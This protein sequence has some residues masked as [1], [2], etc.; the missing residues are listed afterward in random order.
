MS[1][2]DQWQAGLCDM[3]SLS[4]ENNS[5]TFLLTVIDCF[6]KFAWVEQLLNKSGQ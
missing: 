3:G 2:E 6:S 5:Y 1:I 4:K